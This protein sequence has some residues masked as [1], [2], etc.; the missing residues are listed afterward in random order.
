MLLAWAVVLAAHFLYQIFFSGWGRATDVGAS[1]YYSGVL[2]LLSAVTM[3]PLLTWGFGQLHLPA[4]AYPLATTATALLVLGGLLRSFSGPA[5]GLFSLSFSLLGGG[6][7]LLFGV[8][9]LGLTGYGLAPSRPALALAAV[10]AGL[11]LGRTALLAVAPVWSYQHLDFDA[12]QELT[13]RAICA[14]GTGEPL[15]RLNERLPGFVP[16]DLPPTGTLTC[17][18]PGLNYELRFTD[19]RLTG[20]SAGR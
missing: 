8:A 16:P 14:L 6:I 5:L 3:V 1:L 4:W 7:G 11:A 18:E 12:R 17:E 10:L 15:Q 9:Y 13:F 19:G 2:A 20:M